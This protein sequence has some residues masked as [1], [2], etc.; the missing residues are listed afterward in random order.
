MLKEEKPVVMTCPSC[1]AENGC[2]M[3]NYGWGRLIKCFICGFE[4]GNSENETE[5]I[6]VEE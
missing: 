3:K 4:E 5:K 2:Y 1:N 6:V